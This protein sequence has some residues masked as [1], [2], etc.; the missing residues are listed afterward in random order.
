MTVINEER[1]YR[2]LKESIKM[3]K[4][5]RSDTEK[6]NLIGKGKKI[7]IDKVTKRNKIINNSLKTQI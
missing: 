5:Q 4:S 6:I 2:E 3:I 7:G 1:N